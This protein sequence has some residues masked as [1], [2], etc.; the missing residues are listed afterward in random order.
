M[1]TS[2]ERA[3]KGLLQFWAG[4][5][6]V[7]GLVFVFFPN[8]IVQSLNKISLKLTPT[9]PPLPLS[10]ERFWVVLM[11]SLM[12]TLT[13]LCYSAQDDLRRRKDL[14]Q[15]VLISKAVSSLFFLLFF[16]IDRMAFAY[17]A[18]FL[19]DG[20]IFIITVAYYSRALK[21]SQLII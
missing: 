12:I 9:L 6:L 21:S 15:F 16:F 8:W 2:E 1:L 13:F 17:L 7:A 20:S 11:F 5:F 3:L 14:V 19:V 18:G 4:L 10:D